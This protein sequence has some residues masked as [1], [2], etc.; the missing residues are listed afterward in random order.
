M[1]VLTCFE[2]DDVRLAW[3]QHDC[4]WQ[5]LHLIRQIIVIYYNALCPISIDHRAIQN[6]HDIL[7]AVFRYDFKNSCGYE[8]FYTDNILGKS[9]TTAQQKSDSE[10]VAEWENWLRDLL[11]KEHEILKNFNDI[12][13]NQTIPGVYKFEE[14]LEVLLLKKFADIPWTGHLHNAINTPQR[15]ISSQGEINSEQSDNRKNHEKFQNLRLSLRVLSKL[16]ETEA[17]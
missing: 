9:L 15:S 16:S 14:K 7:A 5:T 17:S 6:S 13:E 10:I 1:N 8:I 2:D 4:Y 3:I 12:Y 11:S